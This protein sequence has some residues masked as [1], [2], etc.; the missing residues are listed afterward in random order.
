MRKRAVRDFPFSNVNFIDMRKGATAAFDD[1]AAVRTQRGVVPGLDGTPEQVRVGIVSP[2]FFRVLGA[3]MALGRDFT[4]DDGSCASRP[5][6]RAGRR[7]SPA[8]RSANR[9]SEL[10]LLAAALRR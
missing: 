8:R 9:D 2:N 5:T 10:S 4:D 7:P 6:G 3:R 1:I